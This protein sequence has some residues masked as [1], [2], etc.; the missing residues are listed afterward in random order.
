MLFSSGSLF[1]G[2]PMASTTLLMAATYHARKVAEGES[3]ATFCD[4]E[5]YSDDPGM[6]C[7]ADEDQAGTGGGGGPAAPAGGG[8]DESPLGGDYNKIMDS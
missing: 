8:D 6:D 4:E 5:L 2:S 1:N 3:C 7:A